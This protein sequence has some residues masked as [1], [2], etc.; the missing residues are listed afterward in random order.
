MVH[1]QFNWCWHHVPTFVPYTVE[2][3]LIPLILAQ[4]NTAQSAKGATIVL[5]SLTA[6]A[7]SVF[8]V[9]AE[10]RLSHSNEEGN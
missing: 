9:L 2:G 3:V 10:Y 1:T 6:N 5:Q 4:G 8:K 7:Q